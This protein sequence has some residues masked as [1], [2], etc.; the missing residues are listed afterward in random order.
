MAPISPNHDGLAPRGFAALLID[1]NPELSRM[2]EETSQLYRLCM[3]CGSGSFANDM[4]YKSQSEWT[5]DLSQCANAEYLTKIYR[6]RIEYL[7]EYF[8]WKS[9][10]E[11]GYYDNGENLLP[12]KMKR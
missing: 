7:R 1:Q 2:A 11:R 10:I 4:L 12:C 8:R 3:D 6:Y 5:R 9:E